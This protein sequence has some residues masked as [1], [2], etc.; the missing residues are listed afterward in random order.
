MVEFNKSGVPASMLA[1]GGSAS[2]GAF[3]S[4]DAADA[5]DELDGHCDALH[6]QVLQAKGLRDT[7][8]M[9]DQV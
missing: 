3:G 9:G 2:G 4:R 6:V 5:D 8:F 7:Q 1:A